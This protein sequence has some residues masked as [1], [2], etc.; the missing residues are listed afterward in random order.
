MRSKLCVWLTLPT[1]TGWVGSLPAIRLSIMFGSVQLYHWIAIGCKHPPSTSFAFFYLITS[2]QTKKKSFSYKNPS[3]LLSHVL[4]IVLCTES[5]SQSYCCCWFCRFDCCSYDWPIHHTKTFDVLD[6]L[7]KK[8][9]DYSDFRRL[10]DAF[11]TQR[12]F[13]WSFFFS[14]F[15]LSVFAVFCWL[16]V[17]PFFPLSRAK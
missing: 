14:P 4:Q 5:F 3:D 8:Y 9:F 10:L 6:E 15:Y 16:F 11:D 7:N 13:C 17:R 12:Y 1:S 2:N